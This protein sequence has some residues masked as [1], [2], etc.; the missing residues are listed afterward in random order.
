MGWPNMLKKGLIALTLFGFLFQTLIPLAQTIPHTNNGERLVICTAFGTKTIDI[1]TGAEIPDDEN[2]PDD[3]TE[4]VI[5][6]A[7]TISINMVAIAGATEQHQSS[8]QSLAFP[9]SPRNTFHLQHLT[10]AHGAR[11]PPTA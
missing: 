6:L 5:C 7:K 10:D 2:S 8:F 9:L 11:A 1:A 4:Y 3:T